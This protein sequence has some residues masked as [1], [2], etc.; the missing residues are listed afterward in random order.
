ML[1]YDYWIEPTIMTAKTDES[2]IPER[3]RRCAI[4]R[5]KMW[6]GAQEEAPDILNDATQEYLQMLAQLKASQLPG[7]ERQSRAEPDTLVQGVTW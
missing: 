6:W 5:A 4:A 7:Q 3:Y 2:A 1:T